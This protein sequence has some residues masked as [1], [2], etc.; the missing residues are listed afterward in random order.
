M[1]LGIGLLFATRMPSCSR[2]GTASFD[3]PPADGYRARVATLRGNV[4]KRAERPSDGQAGVRLWVAVALTS[5]WV[6]RCWY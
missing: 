4:L 5:E 3:A 1:A 6:F 2:A